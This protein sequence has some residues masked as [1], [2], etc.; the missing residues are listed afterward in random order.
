MLDCRGKPGCKRR[1]LLRFL[2][3]LVKYA[4]RQMR[5]VLVRF[6]FADVLVGEIRAAVRQRS[7][8]EESKYVNPDLWGKWLA[9]FLCAKLLAEG[10]QT[11]EPFSEDWGWRI[12][13]A[14][15]DFPLWIGCSHY[16]RV[17]RR[18][19]LLHRTSHALYSQAIQ[20]G[21]CAGARCVASARFGHAS[22]RS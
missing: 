19:S 3:V 18:I 11:D 1:A 12:D 5:Q 20:K 2:S 15:E 7:P 22:L 8:I 16:Q 6:E 4:F 9:E 21:R 14:N 13:V 10:V 17:S